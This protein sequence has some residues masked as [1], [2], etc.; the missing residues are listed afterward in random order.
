M[1]FAKSARLTECFPKLP[2]VCSR[3]MH[4]CDHT[5]LCELSQPFVAHMPKAAVPW[6][7]RGAHTY[8][9]GT[10]AVTHRPANLVALV[11]VWGN[12]H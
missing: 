9:E 2:Q 3:H 5:M 11:A 12:V 8:R 6:R 7:G 1:H 4:A 10:A